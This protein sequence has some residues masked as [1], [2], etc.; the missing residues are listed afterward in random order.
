MQNTV[1]IDPTKR[2]PYGNGD[3]R[4][5]NSNFNGIEDLKKYNMTNDCMKTNEARDLTETE[6]FFMDHIVK[7]LNISNL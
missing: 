3:R 7:V 2:F 6:E 5:K 4:K 1:S